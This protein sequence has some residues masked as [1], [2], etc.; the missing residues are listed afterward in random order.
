MDAI[1]VLRHR[2]KLVLK[3]DITVFETLQPTHGDVFLASTFGFV[4]LQI[5]QTTALESHVVEVGA[6]VDDDDEPAELIARLR[7]TKTNRL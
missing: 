2:L 5:V 6:D 3:I 1:G 4:R 7:E